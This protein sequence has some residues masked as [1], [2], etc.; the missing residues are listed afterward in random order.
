MHE[1]PP[2]LAH[3]YP[4]VQGY[5]AIPDCVPQ[6]SRTMQSLISAFAHNVTYDLKLRSALASFVNSTTRP[7]G[8]A[9]ITEANI[10]IVGRGLQKANSTFY[11][12][13]PGVLDT[14]CVGEVYHPRAI[15]FM[16]PPRP[17]KPLWRTPP[18]RA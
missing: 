3:R 4:M 2:Y 15:T 9:D 8:S 11:K 14:T 10:G 17:A 16:P 5:G 7:A 12:M 1:P 13:Q 18:S 6:T